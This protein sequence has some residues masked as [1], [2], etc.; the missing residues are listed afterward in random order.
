MPRPAR[1]DPSDSKTERVYEHIVARHARGDYPA[2]RRLVISR[3]AEEVGVS[4]VPVREALRRLEADR[5][6]EYTHQNGFRIRRLDA[7]D[8]IH[9][10]EAHGV[11]E[12]AAV[13][14]AAPRLRP[15]DIARLRRLN[16]R[17]AAA[18][19]HDAFAAESIAFHRALVAACPN[20][21]LLDMMEQDGTALRAAVVVTT[22][23][24]AERV[25]AE[26]D[27]L[28]DLIEAGASAA[29]VE[30]LARAHRLRTVDAYRE[31]ATSRRGSVI[32]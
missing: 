8:L 1:V 9:A 18:E 19:S 14:L 10:L 13:A 16:A 6:V 32:P 30:A 17:V 24:R 22:P 7:D 4:P 11:V 2:G 21:H 27:A 31:S 12:A 23:A 25:V 26:H 15:A 29:E 5:I 20:A 3:I 28:L